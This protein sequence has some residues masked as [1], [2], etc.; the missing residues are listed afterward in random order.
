M[1]AHSKS[2]LILGDSLINGFLNANARY[3]NCQQSRPY[4]L[5]LVSLNATFFRFREGMLGDT[6]A[7]AKLMAF[8]LGQSPR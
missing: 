1:H 7:L 8:M 2:F 4:S 6:F 5:V 3:R